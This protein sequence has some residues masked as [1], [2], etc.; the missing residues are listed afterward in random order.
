MVEST[1]VTGRQR[2]RYGGSYAHRKKN[3]R[4]LVDEDGSH[5]FRCWTERKLEVFANEMHMQ[6][7]SS[8][9]KRLVV[10]FDVVCWFGD[11]FGVGKKGEHEGCGWEPG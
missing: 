6:A 4:V 7:Q 11:F 5:Q 3:G 9:R 10:P 2:W 8:A 1:F